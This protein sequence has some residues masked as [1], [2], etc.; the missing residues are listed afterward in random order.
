MTPRISVLSIISE[1]ESIQLGRMRITNLEA[2]LFSRL[3]RTLNNIKKFMN[4]S[5]SISLVNPKAAPK[6]LMASGSSLTSPMLPSS[7]TIE[8]K[9]GLNSTP[10]LK[11]PR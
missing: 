11:N 10:K 7:S 8:S 5:F 6:T 2:D 9:F 1:K 4:G 3:T